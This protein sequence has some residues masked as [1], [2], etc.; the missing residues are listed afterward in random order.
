MS[1]EDTLILEIDADVYA[2]IA[3]I[4]AREGTDIDRM[5]RDMVRESIAEAE[6]QK[7]PDR[8]DT[9]GFAGLP[10][11]PR[12][13]YRGFRMNCVISPRSAAAVPTP[14]MTGRR[15]PRTGSGAAERPTEAPADG[16]GADDKGA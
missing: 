14:R 11:A 12:S 15:K 16:G 6:A 9:P 8:T 10:P 2:K 5:I 13:G 1:H 3:A 4:A 7:S